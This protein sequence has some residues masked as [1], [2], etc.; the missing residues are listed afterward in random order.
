MN[1]Q[2]QISALKHG[3]FGVVSMPILAVEM[4]GMHASSPKQYTVA[5]GMLSPHSLNVN[6]LVLKRPGTLNAPNAHVG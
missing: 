3:E 4:K 2:K 1:S 5:W 6:K